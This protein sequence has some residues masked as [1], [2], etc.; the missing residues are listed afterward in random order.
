MVDE[1]FW[2]DRPLPQEEVDDNSISQV[3]ENTPWSSLNVSI[4]GEDIDEC[5][6]QLR[7][8]QKQTKNKS[9][10]DENLLFSRF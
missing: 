8:R 5:T 3:Y 1:V 9:T 4:S 2:S 6:D 7:Q 10:V